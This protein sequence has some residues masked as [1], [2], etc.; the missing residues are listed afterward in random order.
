MILKFPMMKLNPSTELAEKFANLGIS[1]EI[2]RFTATIQFLDNDSSDNVIFTSGAILDTGA[3]FS[4]MPG[5][6]PKEYSNFPKEAHIIWGIVN[7]EPCRIQCDL[8]V[9]PIKL[10]DLE[11]NTSPI[12][13]I[14]IAI[15]HRGDIPLLLGM[16]S[17]LSRYS[18]QF[19][20][21]LESFNLVIPD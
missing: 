16:K 15:A 12:L 4:L 17:L 7:R 10:V 14:P 9:I 1:K 19:E 2:E 3:I 8:L 5:P 11:G 18:F 6:I 21:Q 13:Q 20:S